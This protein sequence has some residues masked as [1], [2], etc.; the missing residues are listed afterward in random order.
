MTWAIDAI[1]IV[2]G[3]LI[4]AGVFLQYGVA[5]ALMC[6]GF[7]LIL[8]ALKAAKVYEVGNVTDRD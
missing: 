8:L 2:G 1:A 7:L 4:V 5:V 3:L 6:G